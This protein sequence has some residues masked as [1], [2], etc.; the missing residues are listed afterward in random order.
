MSLSTRHDGRLAARQA[1]TERADGAPVVVLVGNP[2]VGKSTLFNRVTGARQRVVNAPRTTV[3]LATG[4]WRDPL[5]PNGVVTLTDLPGAYDTDP[6]SP[7]EQV[8][9]DVLTGTR[10]VRPDVAV[11][12]LDAT[13]LG[14]SLY[15]LAQVSAAAVPIVVAVTMSDVAQSRGVDGKYR[16]AARGTGPSRHRTRS[17]HG[18]WPP[19][20][21]GGRRRGPCRR[22]DNDRQRAPW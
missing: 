20:A 13:A 17:P 9:M 2:N 4:Q 11:V 8:T 3:E 10:S 22:R 12:L 14:R 5:L 7:D 1:V 19:R 15:L 21:R 18:E 16:K 6:A